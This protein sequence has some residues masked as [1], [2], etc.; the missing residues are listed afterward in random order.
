MTITSCKYCAHKHICKHIE[1]FEKFKQ[2]IDKFDASTDFGIIIK[3]KC[4]KYQ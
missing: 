3:I 4:S 1:E 2:Y